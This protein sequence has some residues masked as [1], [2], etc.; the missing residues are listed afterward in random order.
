MIYRSFKRYKGSF[1]I[2]LIG[3]SAG[4]ACVLMIFLWISDELNVDKFHENDSQ[5]FQVMENQN[6][7]NGVITQEATPDLLAEALDEEIPEIEYATTVTPSFWFGKIPLKVGETK[8]KEVG[9]F[10]GKDFFKMF[11]F[12]VVDGAPAEVLTDKSSIVIS[13]TLAMK[14][15]NTTK[16]IK[17]KVI[18]WELGNKLRQSQITG[19][20][21]DLPY[22]STERFDFV[23]P[24]EV[25]K[26]FS[27]EIGRP[28]DWN[29]N[30]PNTYL[31]V[32][33]GTVV[34]L[35]NN[36][37][38]EFI[39]K[40]NRESN[41]TL[42]VRP[43]SDKYLYGKYDNGVQAGGRI[44]YVNLF[45]AIAL[46]ILVIACINFMN[47][48]TAKA[49]RRTKEVGIK[50]AIGAGR[51]KLIFQYLGES[52]L[53]AFSSLLISL[54][55]VLLLLPKFNELTGKHL[56]LNFDIT[57]ILSF[58]GITVFTGLL[59]GSYPALYLS[60]FK[61]AA[62]LKGK[63]T[64]SLGELWTRRGLV[65][66]QFILSVIL[67][68]SVLVV[69]KQIQFVQSNN[70]GYKKDNVVYFEQKGI[71]HE[72]LAS[73]IEEVKNIPGVVNASSIV[74][75]IVGS[76]N[77]TTELSWK[78]KNPSED[79]SFRFVG[80]N[81]DMMETLGMEMKTGRTFSRNFSQEDTK[82]IFNE[83]AIEIMGLTDPIGEVIN[84]WG[85]NK[86]IIGV[87]KNFHFES[88]HE[89]VKPLFI[90]LNP[91]DRTTIVMVKISSGKEKGII[92]QLSSWYEKYLGYPL[93]YRFLDED[94]QMQYV[95]ERRVLVLSRYFAGL[96]ILISCFGLFALVTFTVERR[97]KEIG[98]RKVLGASHLGI[99]YVLSKEFARMVIVA[100]LIALPL[101]YLVTKSWLDGFVYRINL[102]WWFF[103][104]AGLTVLV[105][106]LLTVGMQTFKA[107]RS[108]L[109]DCL[110]DE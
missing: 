100:I 67:I 4:L 94:Y 28:M 46:F 20:F 18:E 75:N 85:S 40:R 68:V 101:S 55:I 17:G 108:N 73:F 103:I 82:I 79:V 9:Q 43:Y 74:E 26:D 53:M 86:E 8:L 38:A 50:K 90:I 64:A 84:L 6:V 34:S 42:F 95:A 72:N 47:L 25:F 33:E 66:F 49:S 110:K 23:L 16:N 1:F 65:V 102:E 76:V 22:K 37:I 71:Q 31:Q 83:A 29:N 56:T 106:A 80:V 87:V 10:A 15:F 24:Y 21:K 104:G 19:V 13:E 14:L 48:S 59:A 41:T 36:K 63:L 61:P 89:D 78:D 99:A 35:I 3:L 27:R 98:I 81:Y 58:L 39:K 88:F 51:N 45:S 7:A 70:L 52:M 11:S 44:E 54:L 77:S 12:K 92:Q 109:V 107:A 62:I 105:I 32:R 30:G 5:L 60:G 2:N 91:P 93:E 96:A 97:V 57:L 69:Y